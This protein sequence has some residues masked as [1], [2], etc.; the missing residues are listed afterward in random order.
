MLHN[1]RAKSILNVKESG[2]A[3]TIAHSKHYSTSGMQGK[4][5]I[6]CYDTVSEVMPAILMQILGQQVTG[7]NSLDAIYDGVFFSNF[8]DNAKNELVSFVKEYELFYNNSTDLL[9][10]SLFVLNKLNSSD[11]KFF[12]GE[13]TV[14]YADSIGS[15]FIVDKEDV[16]YTLPCKSITC[17]GV[18]LDTVYV[19]NKIFIPF[20]QIPLVSKDNEIIKMYDEGMYDAILED[21]VMHLY[22]KPITA[23]STLNVTIHVSMDAMLHKTMYDEEKYDY[24]YNNLR[25]ELIKHLFELKMENVKIYTPDLIRLVAK[26]MIRRPENVKSLVAELL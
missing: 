24:L 16:D 19:S 20:M 7:E 10:L 21:V 13:C 26:Q 15:A 22:C 12:K 9:Q 18:T 8:S 11:L 25:A 14:N 4:V 17:Y 5:I 6:K 1:K 3:F 2:D 23:F